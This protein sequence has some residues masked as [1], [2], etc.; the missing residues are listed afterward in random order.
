MRSRVPI[1]ASRSLTGGVW[2]N[3]GPVLVSL[4]IGSRSQES[5]S[6]SS[7]L[8]GHSGPDSIWSDSAGRFV[9]APIT[10]VYERRTSRQLTRLLDSEIQVAWAH[11][12]VAVDVRAGGVLNG[13][14]GRSAPRWATGSLSFWISPQVAL[15]GEATRQ[16]ASG[17][18][19]PFGHRRVTIGVRLST[20]PFSRPSTATVAP[21]RP[22]VSE[23]RVRS[24]GTG[25]VVFSVRA[26][27]ARVVELSGDFLAWKPVTL[28]RVS[29]DWW[30]LRFSLPSGPHRVNLRLDG[31][32]WIAPPGVP[33]LRDEFGGHVGVIVVP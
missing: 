25:T 8:V 18:E 14:G 12:K 28:E 32:N 16:S 7:V 10:P 23:F 22:A 33:T 17:V 15:I 1:G 5:V 11:S 31:A 9:P 3:A 27:H 2:R 19:R 4:S 21:A 30:E 6:L 20:A 29:T 13:Q 24:L 26:P